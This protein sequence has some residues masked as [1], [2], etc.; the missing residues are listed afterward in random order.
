MCSGGARLPGASRF[1][2]ATSR[3]KGQQTLPLAFEL[4]SGAIDRTCRPQRARGNR[5][6][7][8]HSR[9]AAVLGSTRR[10]GGCI[11]IAAS[12][13]S[14]PCWKHGKWPLTCYDRT[15]APLA[16]SAE[17][18]HGK[19]G[20]A[21]SIPAGGSTTNQQLR[22]GPAPGLS[23]PRR[24]KNRQWPAI[25]QQITDSGRTN[26]LRGDR[27]EKF[28]VWSTTLAARC[29]YQLAALFDMDESCRTPVHC[30]PQTI[31]GRA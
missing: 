8:V 21:G 27:L 17:H 16:Q 5:L 13:K 29:R 30:C 22:P 1:S 24:K 19:D 6:G 25:C 10:G 4:V 9:P 20:V 3:L 11:W 2:G 15:R 23:H 18:I 31:T 12:R 14:S 28:A 26:T 7:R